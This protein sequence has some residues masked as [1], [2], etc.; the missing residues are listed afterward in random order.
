MIRQR[1]RHDLVYFLDGE[2][3]I[4][5][6]YVLAFNLSLD[7][8]E[9]REASQY[10]TVLVSLILADFEELKIVGK[11]RRLHNLGQCVVK[12]I[13]QTQS[14]VHA[15]HLEVVRVP[16]PKERHLLAHDFVV[17][18]CEVLVLILDYDINFTF[19]FLICF[20]VFLVRG[21]RRFDDFFLVVGHAWLLWS[22]LPLRHYWIQ[23][24]LPIN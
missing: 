24:L 10:S 7:V 3:L 16:V 23:V 18:Y 22:V 14:A 20:P 21:V 11:P 19:Q 4:V 6:L 2:R 17:G 1:V 9:V 8:S 12:R 5:I 13:V 15:F